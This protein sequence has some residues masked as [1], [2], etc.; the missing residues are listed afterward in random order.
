MFTC[1][2]VNASKYLQTDNEKR[3]LPKNKIISLIYNELNKEKALL[4]C[5]FLPMQAGKSG[6]I[7][8]VG[9]LFGRPSLTFSQLI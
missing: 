7:A 8:L 6:N 4:F 2:I 3:T 1:Q 9:S 5:F